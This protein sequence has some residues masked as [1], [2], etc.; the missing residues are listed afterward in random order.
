M[1]RVKI[2]G[3]TREVDVSFA[4]L[5]GADA[6]GFIVGFP[7]SPRNITMEKAATLAK[8]VP[9]FVD[10]VLVSNA[11]TVKIHHGFHDGRFD[12][13]QLYGD[14]PDPG[15]LRKMTGAKLIRAYPAQTDDVEA[16]KAALKGFDALLTDTFVESRMSGVKAP[17]SWPICRKLKYSIA[18]TPLILSGGLNATNVA[19]AI[20]MVKPFAVDVS[21]GVESVPGLKDP[22]KVMEFIKKAKVADW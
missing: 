7:T 21:S 6:V 13:L 14:V 8:S 9:P 22:G 1:I 3:I 20:K 2:C 11:E 16:A 5:A 19:A 18:P 17:P 10:A 4:V 12:A 15:E